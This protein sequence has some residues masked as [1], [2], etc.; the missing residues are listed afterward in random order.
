MTPGQVPADDTDMESAEEKK[1]TT[2]GAES[3]D[4]SESM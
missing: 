4:D 2:E 1:E 3:G